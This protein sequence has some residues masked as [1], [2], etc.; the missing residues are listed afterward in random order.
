[1]VQVYEGHYPDYVQVCRAYGCKGRT[2][3][4]HV[5]LHGKQQG[6]SNGN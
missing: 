6:K 5:K 2:R 1:M 3:V 4:A